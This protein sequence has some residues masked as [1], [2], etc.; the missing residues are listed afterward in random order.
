MCTYRDDAQDA[1]DA[2]VRAARSDVAGRSLPPDVEAALALILD[3]LY[4]PELNVDYILASAQISDKAFSGK[5]FYHVGLHP[6]AYIEG[7]RLAA[8]RRL[9]ESV[10]VPAYFAAYSVGYENYRTFARAF[11]R[12]FRHAPSCCAEFEAGAAR[13][14]A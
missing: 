7:L 2:F 8:A 9:M 14:A 13:L 4:E 1:L 11:K 6:R 10:S 5:F 3:Q 12:V